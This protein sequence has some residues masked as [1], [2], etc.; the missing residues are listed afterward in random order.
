[1]KF[2]AKVRLLARL[3]TYFQIKKLV[4]ILLK[5]IILSIEE[6]KFHR[7]KSQDNWITLKVYWSVVQN[8]EFY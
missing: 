6:I 2:L 4:K 7:K 1:M 8:T 3:L 5:E